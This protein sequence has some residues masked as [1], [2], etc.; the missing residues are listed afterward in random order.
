MVQHKAVITGVDPDLD[1]NTL[2]TE[3]EERNNLRVTNLARL[4]NKEDR[5]K[6][7]KVIIHLEN[8]EVQRR[9]LKTHYLKDHVKSLVG[10]WV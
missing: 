1:D 10:P 2:K 6:T 9:V 8:E 3:L 4:L 7:Y 5:T